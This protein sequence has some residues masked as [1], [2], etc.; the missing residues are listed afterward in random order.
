MLGNGN[1]PRLC[2]GI[3]RRVLREAGFKDADETFDKIRPANF[4]HYLA[5]LEDLEAVDGSMAL[6][7]RRMARHQLQALSNCFGAREI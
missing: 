7:L 4:R 5:L 1:S 3:F 6:T 2:R